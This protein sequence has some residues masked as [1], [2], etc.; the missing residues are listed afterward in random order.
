M[1]GEPLPS[2]DFLSKQETKGLN[3]VPIRS[4]RLKLKKRNILIVSFQN[5]TKRKSFSYDI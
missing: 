3:G 5:K 2:L 1:T 4:D